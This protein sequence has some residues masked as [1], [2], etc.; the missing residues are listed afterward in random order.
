MP[1]VL[2]DAPTSP[3]IAVR[4]PATQELIG[5]VPS[6]TAE[7]VAAAAGR[8][9]AAQAQWAA[10][11]ISSRLRIF[12]RFAELLCQQKEAVAAVICREAGKP[13]AESLSTEILV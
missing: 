13:E 11:S 10:T 12:R 1:A 6:F 5:S 8:A 7:Q 3:Q 9:A 2:T 4:N